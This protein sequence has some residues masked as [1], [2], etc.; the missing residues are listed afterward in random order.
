M[1]AMDSIERERREYFVIITN[2]IIITILIQFIP[3]LF[4]Q[5]NYGLLVV[6]LLIIIVLALILFYVMVKPRKIDKEFLAVLIYDLQNK[7]FIP[8][9]F[10][11]ILAE[12]SLREAGR[13]LIE[14]EELNSLIKGEYRSV[15]DIAKRVEK[16]VQALLVEWLHHVVSEFEPPH[17]R[18]GFQILS[19]L[20]TE[21]LSRGIS[22]LKEMKTRR[23]EINPRDMTKNPYMTTMAFIELPENTGIKFTECGIQLCHKQAKISIDVKFNGLLLSPS[24]IT[25][26]YFKQMQQAFGRDLKDLLAGRKLIEFLCIVHFR[27]EV[28]RWA[29]DIHLRWAN[30]LCKSLEEFLHWDRVVRNSLFYSRFYR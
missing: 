3:P 18:V 27:A 7:Y 26:P 16:L 29:K 10:Y 12:Q 11:A 30:E 25:I 5:A 23:V 15:R 4:F 14:D 6:S 2:G 28:S 24:T 19:S 21:L 17:A 8:T 9:G 1:N 20:P 22:S 13:K